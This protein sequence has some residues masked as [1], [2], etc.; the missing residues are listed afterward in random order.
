MKL[1][2]WGKFVEDNE[3]FAEHEL[4]SRYPKL[5]VTLVNLLNVFKGDLCYLSRWTSFGKV[6]YI[7]AVNEYLNYNVDN[8][9]DFTIKSKLVDIGCGDIK[10]PVNVL[11]SLDNDSKHK[12]VVVGEPGEVHYL[13]KENMKLSDFLW[14]QGLVSFSMKTGEGVIFMKNY[15]TEKDYIREE[16][17]PD[18]GVKAKVAEIRWLLKNFNAA[19]K[20]VCSHSAFDYPEC[21]SNYYVCET[22]HVNEK[23]DEKGVYEIDIRDDDGRPVSYETRKGDS[24]YSVYFQYMVEKGYFIEKDMGKVKKA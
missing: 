6:D 24:L 23:Q 2:Y 5:I 18:G 7:K 9:D 15:I 3:P 1:T 19:N 11:N 4:D 14:E 13:L 8:F 21:Y 16:Y 12:I 17:T 22:I 10:I 20:N